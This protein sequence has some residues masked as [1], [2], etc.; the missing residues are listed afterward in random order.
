MTDERSAAAI[1]EHLRDHLTDGQW[2][3]SC[4]YCKRRRRYGG[5]G[6]TPPQNAAGEADG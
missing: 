6:V 2:H 3:D 4:Q 1:A 5:N